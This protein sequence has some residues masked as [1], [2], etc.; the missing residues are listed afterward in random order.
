ML[1]YGLKQLARHGKKPI[2]G[3]LHAA[4]VLDDHLIM[5][6]EPQHFVPVLKPKIDGTLPLVLMRYI[7]CEIIGCA[8]AYRL[9]F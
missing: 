5:D 4:G 3:V 2:K 7:A 6:L 8:W 9:P 1:L